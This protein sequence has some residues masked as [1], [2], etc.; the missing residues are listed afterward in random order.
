MFKLRILD[1]YEKFLFHIWGPQVRNAGQSLNRLGLRLQ[2]SL[3]SDDRGKRLNEFISLK[4][5]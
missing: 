1:A 5:N 4:F 3:A 2:G